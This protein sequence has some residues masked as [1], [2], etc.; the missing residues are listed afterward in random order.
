MDD[1]RIH[2][3]N[4]AMDGW[5]GEY[6]E[7]RNTSGWSTSNPDDK[8]QVLLKII[9]KSPRRTVPDDDADALKLCERII[10]HYEGPA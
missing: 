10:L 6:D 3:Q 8:K 1:Q 5:E 7:A 2:N 9:R 4:D